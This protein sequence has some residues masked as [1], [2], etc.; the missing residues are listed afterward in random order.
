MGAMKSLRKP[1]YATEH[2]LLRTWLTNKR[3]LG[4]FTQR[5]L[6]AK[7]DVVHSFVA[8]VERGERRLDVIEFVGYCRALGVQ[9]IE[10]IDE[11]N[12]QFEL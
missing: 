6:A 5:D 2:V 1:I 4:N 9:P 10:F 12:Q 11:L 8:K 3:E 7:M